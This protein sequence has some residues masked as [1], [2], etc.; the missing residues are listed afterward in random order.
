[1]EGR[2]VIGYIEPIHED[3]LTI[4]SLVDTVR[5]VE[6]GLVLAPIV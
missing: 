6:L 2:V 4:A 5:R 1:M 3:F